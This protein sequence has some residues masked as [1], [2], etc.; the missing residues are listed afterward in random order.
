MQ[1]YRLG[2][3]W[4]ESC[5]EEGDFRVLFDSW[6]DVIQQCA[7]VA[8]KANG[9]LAHISPSVSSRT[10][11]V[12]VPLFSELSPLGSAHS[13]VVMVLRELTGRSHGQD[14]PTDTSSLSLLLPEA[15][16][17][18]FSPCW[19][20]MLKKKSGGKDLVQEP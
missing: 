4:L 11:E 10:R 7:Q 16:Q 14:I 9:I 3:E 8:K 6:L 2:E 13:K 18:A 12:I 5:P 19:E 15:T 1:C 20:E 17:V